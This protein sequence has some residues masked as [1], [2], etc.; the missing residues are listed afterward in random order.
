LATQVH[1]DFAREE[2][3]K[4]GSERS[5]GFVF[6]VFCGL[7]AGYQL[8]VGNSVLWWWAGAAA[9]FAVVAAA[10][11]VALRP[12][13]I[14]WFK[15]GMLLH[16]IVSP[17][18][19]GLMFFAVFTPIGLWMRLVGKRPLSLRLQKEAKSYWVL[20]KPPGPPPGSFNR[21]F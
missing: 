20:R 6:A 1:E 19:L 8:W 9:A 10:V 18:V 14:V 21:Q 12:L 2:I 15:F 13:N 4:A 16:H 11:P 3:T 7:V 5:F 17:V